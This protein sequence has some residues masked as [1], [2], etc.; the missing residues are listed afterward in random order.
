VA[1]HHRLRAREVDHG[2]GHAGQ[3]AGV[4][5][6][7]AAGTDPLRHVLEDRRRRIAWI[8]RARRGDRSNDVEHVLGARR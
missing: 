8:V 7:T 6:G 4:E 3:P 5:L 2:R 1:Q